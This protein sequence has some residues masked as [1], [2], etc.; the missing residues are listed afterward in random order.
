MAEVALAVQSITLPEARMPVR[1]RDEYSTIPTSVAAPFLKLAV[2][3][4][5]SAQP[6]GPARQLPPDTEL[7]F[8][9]RNPLRAIIRYNPNGAAATLNYGWR[10]E[11]TASGPQGS[12]F[13][14][15]DM[16]EALPIVGAIPGVLFAPHGDF[17]FAAQYNGEDYIWIDG[18][19]GVAVPSLLTITFAA[20]PGATGMFEIWR[21]NNGTPVLFAGQSTTAAT[22]AYP[23]TITVSD[24]YKVYA[25][26]TNAAAS[27]NAKT[28]S[29][30]HSSTCSIWEHRYLPG[31]FDNADELT[32]IRIN[33]AAIRWSNNAAE[34]FRSGRVVGIQLDKGQYWYGVASDPDP[35]SKLMS[36]AAN[37]DRPF[38]KGIYGFLKGTEDNDFRMQRPFNISNWGMSTANY[39][40]EEESGYLAVCAKVVQTDGRDSWAAFYYGIEFTSNNTWFDRVPPTLLPGAWEQ[41]MEAVASLEQWYENPVHWR[42]IISTIGKIAKVAAPIL[43]IFGGRG[44]IAGAIAQG[45]GDVATEVSTIGVKKRRR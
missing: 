33:A 5:D 22:L 18:L 34:N 31:I 44:R 17:L 16:I 1:Q 4:Q 24:Y 2:S 27:V 45:V 29:I 15:L 8:M 6:A 35:F 9:T 3:W 26:Q 20:D 12:W 40:L 28:I 36:L 21:Y 23:I 30:F 32:G 37:K 38:D 10:R 25:A 19:V 13:L 39:P 11:F 42:D 41:A 7:L 14:G 43:G